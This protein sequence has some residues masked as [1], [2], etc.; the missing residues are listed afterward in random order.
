M[1]N[2]YVWSTK[3]VTY[4]DLIKDKELPKSLFEK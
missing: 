3:G 4:G 2:I 1:L